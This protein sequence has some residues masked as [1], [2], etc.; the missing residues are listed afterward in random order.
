MAIHL[1]SGA[2]AA[3][4]VLAGALALVGCTGT[5]SPTPDPTGTTEPDAGG[6]PAVIELLGVRDQTGAVAYTGISAAKGTALAVKQAAEEAFLGEGVTVEVDERD[7]AFDPT[8]ASTAITEGLASGNISAIL[9]PQISNEALAVAPIAEAAQVPIVFTQSGVDGLL[10]GQFGYR[11]SSSQSSVWPRAI[12]KIVADG[13]KTVVTFVSAN[14]ATY[15]QLGTVVIPPLLADG[16]VE[17]AQTFDFESSVTDFAAA[18]GQAAAASPDAIVVTLIGPQMPTLITQLRQ[19]GYEGPVYVT[20]AMTDDQ[21]KSMGD[22]GHDV[23]FPTNFSYAI[24]SGLPAEF[25]KAFQAEFGENPDTYAAETYDQTWWVLRAIKQANSADPIA[26][27]DALLAL[28]LQG[29]EGVQGK[30]T[31]IDG[32]DAV[33]PGVLVE[34]D[35]VAAVQKIAG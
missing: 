32:R 4:I 5:T 27:N 10:T 30:L 28:G 34:W 16:G 19:S 7:G 21:M 31:F 24:S 33:S 13:A 23:F 22:A 18:A 9:G 29:F 6:L 14:N 2:A 17:I 3:S 35:P 15:N 26:I 12:E 11:A 1:R 25:T 8:V 20:A